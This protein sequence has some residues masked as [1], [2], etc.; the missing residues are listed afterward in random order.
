[1]KAKEE[2]LDHKLALLLPLKKIT[3]LYY[4]TNFKNP[5]DMLKQ[6]ILDML[7]SNL[8]TVYVHNLSKF[9][10][11]FI[12]NILKE[13]GDITS[14]YKLNRDGKILSISVK[15]KDKKLKGRFIFRDSLLLIQGSLKDITKDFNAEHGKLSFPHKFVKADNLNYVGDKPDF[16]FY[17]DIDELDYESIPL[18][19]DV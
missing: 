17:T 5:R 14:D 15:F 19:T 7:N 3:K 18:K 2:Y 16:N 6:C 11:L 12:N 4:I 1:M 8:G 9:D 13:D 10:V